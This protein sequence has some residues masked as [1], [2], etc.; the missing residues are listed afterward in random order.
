MDLI[1]A[2]GCLDNRVVGGTEPRE[3]LPHLGLPDTGLQ[4]GWGRAH[5]H[6]LTCP[7]FITHSPTGA[8]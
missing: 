3:G 2:R 7:S 5:V 1:L 8:T 6:G 4:D